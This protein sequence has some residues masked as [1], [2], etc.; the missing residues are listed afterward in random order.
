VRLRIRIADDEDLIRK[1]LVRLLREEDYEVDAVGTAA[2]VMESVRRDPPHVLILDLRFPDGSGLDLLP[3]LKALAPE[4]KVVVITA[5]GDL[6]TAVEAMR[7][8]ATDFLKK[9]YEM[10]EMLLA[11]ERLQTGLVR[12]TQLDAFRR[13]ELEAFLKTRIVGESPAIR[14]IWEIVEKVAS[15]EATTVL[16][17][18]ESGTGKELVA[19]AI[20][21]QSSRKD[22]PF[23]ALNCSSFQEQLLENEMFGHERG[24]FTDARE[25]KRGLVELT[26]QGTLFLDEVGDLPAATQ[27][28][29]PSS[30]WAAPRT[31]SSISASWPRP[32]ATWTPPCARGSSATTSTTVSRSSRSICRRSAS[33]ETT[34]SSW[35]AT[36]S[37]STT[38]SSGSGSTPSKGRP[39]RSSAPTTGPE[40]C[41]SSGTCSS[42]S[43]SSR[44]T[45]CCARTTCLPR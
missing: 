31:W 14:R 43:C 7:R 3:R 26:D 6:P 19:R 45:R 44:T 39:S 36:S 29:G 18:G 27:A 2:E 32:T 10:Q 34:C 24:A 15:S 13:G 30:A 41:G 20:H 22:A 35:P 37:S 33:V 12:E 5:F 1:S 23:M 16:I 21:F 4:M 17:E 42:G 25:P 8:G 11:V 9:P 38:R 40:T 28:T